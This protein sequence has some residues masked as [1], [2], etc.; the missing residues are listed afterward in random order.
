MKIKSTNSSLMAVMVTIMACFKTTMAA[1]PRNLRSGMCAPYGTGKARKIC[2]KYCI[3]KKDI[4]DAER[5]YFEDHTGVTLPCDPSGP[6][7]APTTS[8]TSSPTSSPTAAPTSNPTSSPTTSSIGQVFSSCDQMTSETNQMFIFTD[9]YS[10]EGYETGDTVNEDT[11]DMFSADGMTAIKGEITYYESDNV[12]SREFG[13]PG[14]GVGLSGDQD[15][16][17]GFKDL[18][19]YNED[20]CDD[21]LEVCGV[22]QVCFK[23]TWVD[24]ADATIT[25]DDGSTENLWIHDAMEN[26]PNEIGI[27]TTNG[28]T[29][30]SIF[31]DTH[32]TVWIDEISF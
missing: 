10:D 31:I 12:V 29:I 30:E 28:R 18:S 7:S 5:G 17:L 8:P 22:T 11:Y 26:P 16:F 27:A 32:N 4:T 9:D 13:Q 1:T 19:F 2:L 25:Y 6:T 15:L 24:G 14:F 21:S 3:E 23:F 20:N